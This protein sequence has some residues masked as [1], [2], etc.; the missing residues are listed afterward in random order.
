MPVCEQALKPKHDMHFTAQRPT[1][2][3]HTWFGLAM[4]SVKKNHIV[5]HTLTSS[6]TAC[7]LLQFWEQKGHVNAKLAVVLGPIPLVPFNSDA[8]HTVGCHRRMVRSFEP[9]AMRAW[10][11]E[12]ATE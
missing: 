3:S 6:H 10:V 9:E 2:S 8:T 4:L 11:G 5:D 12:K 1:T 7:V